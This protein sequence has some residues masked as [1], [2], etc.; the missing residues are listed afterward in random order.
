M[1][2]INKLRKHGTHYR[3][4]IIGKT[5]HCSAVVAGHKIGF[6]IL[7][8]LMERP[9]AAL[10]YDVGASGPSFSGKSLTAT[11]KWCQ[12][13]PVDKPKPAGIVSLAGSRLI[14]LEL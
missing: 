6:F 9:S 7:D 1:R 8:S 14:S 3:E 2:A 11:I 13:N 4:F 12:A 5:Y 10:H